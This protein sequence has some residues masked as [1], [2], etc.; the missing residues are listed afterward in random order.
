MKTLKNSILLL[1]IL[2]CLPTSSF[3]QEKDDIWAPREKM[4]QI[5][6]RGTVTE[7]NP[8]T[9]EITL[10][11]TEGAQVTVT[12]GEEVKRFD[13]IAVNDVIEFDYYLYLKA[14]FREPTAEEKAEPV[15]VVVEE[16]IAPDDMAPGA[17]V[18]AVIKAV[19]TIEALN[20]PN[21]FATVSGPNGN[22]VMI[23]I[24]DA[25][26]MTK[27]RIGQVVILTYAEAMAVSLEKVAVAN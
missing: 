13:E 12:A 26:F 4:E 5:T 19:V 27:L 9:R 1:L 14:E 7:I 16:G 2:T 6:M 23:P 22:Y 18:G 10:T 3:S 11:N 24:E 21:M 25:E 8:E 15:Q 20:R 17:V